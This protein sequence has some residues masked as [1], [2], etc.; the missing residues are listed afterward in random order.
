VNQIL[1]LAFF[2]PPSPRPH[3]P[4]LTRIPS[5]SLGVFILS[6]CTFASCQFFVTYRS[7]SFAR[8]IRG[9]PLPTVRIVLSVLVLLLICASVVAAACVSP[10]PP[11]P[12]SLF[13]LASRSNSAETV[14]V[15]LPPLACSTSIW[16]LHA[17]PDDLDVT[18]KSEGSS[19]DAFSD[20]NALLISVSLS[21]AQTSGSRLH[22]SLCCE[23]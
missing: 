20:A 22:R 23:L 15:A 6:V 11:L 2:L 17:R 3:T 9:R 10:R 18:Y 21:R 19:L 14:R 1:R 16:Y 7:V 8:K 12:S 5:I 13:F 4:L